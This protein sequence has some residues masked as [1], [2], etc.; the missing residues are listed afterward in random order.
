MVYWDVQYVWI[1]ESV[2]YNVVFVFR[3]RFFLRNENSHIHSAY[4]RV[5]LCSNTV[6]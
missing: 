5:R 1:Y 4:G 3:I 2:Q 6:S